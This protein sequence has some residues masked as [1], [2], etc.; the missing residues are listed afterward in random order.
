[1]MSAGLLGRKKKRA[2]LFLIAPNCFRLSPWREKCE[3]LKIG[4]F[5]IFFDTKKLFSLFFLC[6]GYVLQPLA[7]TDVYDILNF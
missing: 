5:V 2:K 6:E 4:S 7:A 1:M 3:E